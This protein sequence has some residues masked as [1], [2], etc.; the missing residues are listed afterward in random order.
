MI[1]QVNVDFEGTPINATELLERITD[2]KVLSSKVC[3]GSI[4]VASSASRYNTIVMITDC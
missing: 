4:F 3:G 2:M 1:V